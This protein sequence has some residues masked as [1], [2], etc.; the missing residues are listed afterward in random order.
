MCKAEIHNNAF[1]SCGCETWSLA[2][3]DAQRLRVFMNSVLRGVF[4]TGGG[5]SDRVMEKII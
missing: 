5:G 3:R 4:E 1:Y 2:F